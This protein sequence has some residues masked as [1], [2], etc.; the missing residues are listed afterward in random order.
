MIFMNF[1]WKAC[2]WFGLFY[3]FYCIGLAEIF[4]IFSGIGV[5]FLNLG[6]RKGPSAYSVF[7]ENCQKLAGDIDPTGFSKQNVNQKNL[8]NPSFLVKNHR[9]A[10]KPCPCGSGKKHKKCCLHLKETDDD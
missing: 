3:C 8:A 9:L 5:I 2:V 1:Y 4:C 10:N 7:N 6:E